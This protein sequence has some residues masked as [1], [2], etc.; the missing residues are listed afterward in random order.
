[1]CLR[2]QT[3]ETRVICNALLFFEDYFLF[4]ALL[5]RSIWHLAGVD[6]W[7]LGISKKIGVT[8]INTVFLIGGRSGG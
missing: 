7:V 4:S 8:E 2:T 1:M 6:R 3:E 5:D